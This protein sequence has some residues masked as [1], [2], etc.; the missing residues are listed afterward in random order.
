VSPIE[1]L[2]PIAQ[3]SYGW[4]PFWLAVTS[5]A[6]A[7][8]A[9]YGPLVVDM[10]LK[11]SADRRESRK[12]ERQH[13]VAPPPALPEAT[14]EPATQREPAALRPAQ[15]QRAPAP[16]I[17]G[18]VPS[19]AEVDAR[20]ADLRAEVLREVAEAKAETT[21]LAERLDRLA[22]AFERLKATVLR[23]IKDFAERLAKL[24]GW[25]DGW[26]NGGGPGSRRR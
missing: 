20:I 14:D 25:L 13:P 5:A 15:A 18:D 4:F 23:G 19:R 1:P 9:K 11:I 8:V 26:I 17:P 22:R 2:K 10:Y 6:G 3:D 7:V 24:E 12:L 16:S 21:R